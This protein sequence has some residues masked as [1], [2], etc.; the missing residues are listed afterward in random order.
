MGGWIGF[1]F[2]VFGDLWMIG[3]F[4][5]C[6][7]CGFRALGGFPGGFS[8]SWGWYNMGFGWFGWVIWILVFGEFVVITMVAS[9]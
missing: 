5:R 3:W 7:F 8:S 2:F 9:L 4:V 6:G 1:G